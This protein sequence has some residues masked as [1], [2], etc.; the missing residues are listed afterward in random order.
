MAA[1]KVAAVAPDTAMGRAKRDRLGAARRK[2]G[3]KRA[4]GGFAHLGRAPTH[5]GS[6]WAPK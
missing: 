1:I 3:G 5:L 4:V 6:S 2:R